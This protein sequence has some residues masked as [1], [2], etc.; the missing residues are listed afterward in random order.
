MTGLFPFWCR[1]SVKISKSRD[2]AKNH[3]RMCFRKTIVLRN[4]SMRL[5]VAGFLTAAAAGRE[6]F[7]RSRA[8]SKPWLAV[9]LAA[10]FCAIGNSVHSADTVS[11]RYA[12]AYSAMRSIF[13]LPVSVAAREGF[14]RREGLNVNVIVPLPGGSD[15]MVDALYDDTADVT[16][17]ATPFLIRSALAGTD[18][19]AIAAEFNNPIYSLV[20]KPAIKSFADLRGKLLGLADE[21]GSITISTRKLLALHGLRQGDFQ[22][23]TIEGTPARFTCLRRGECMAVPLGQPQDLLAISEGYRLLGISTEAVPEFLYT[24]TAVRR[25]WAEAHKDALVRYVRGLGSAFKFIR[26]P[27][28][29]KAVAKTIIE[30]TGS[31][32]AIAERTLALFFEP[33]RKVLPQ[34][35][36]IDVKGLAQV[37]AFMGEAGN[38]KE[39]L[40]A[41][42]H[43]VD[44]QYLRLA[45]IN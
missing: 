3:L 14:F 13:S 17:I 1:I 7:L 6:F 8:N 26:D 11:L 35:G 16:H 37:I 34:Q 28:K 31:T 2:A 12:Q 27:A 38:L 19:V 44:L 15:K 42:E 39:P 40:P 30:T 43:F 21:A 25:S 18:V 4:D 45:G 41:P 33:E 24:V 32:A 36:E 9:G 29:R 20:A 23:K 10:V 22:V 5:Y